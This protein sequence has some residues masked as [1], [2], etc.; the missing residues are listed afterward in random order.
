[1]IWPSFFLKKTCFPACW[2]HLVVAL[3]DLPLPLLRGHGLDE[4]GG[5]ELPQ[6]LRDGLQLHLGL[7]KLDAVDQGPQ[8]AGLLAG[9]LVVAWKKG[10]K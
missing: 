10:K 7:A 5:D 2:P 4:V 6:H 8:H 9:A 1:M 3:D